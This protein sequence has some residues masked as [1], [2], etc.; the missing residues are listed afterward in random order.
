MTSAQWTP[1][2]KTSLKKKIVLDTLGLQCE[3]NLN[4]ALFRNEYGL[5]PQEYLPSKKIELEC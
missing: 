3:V 1:F 5:E 2:T 4:W